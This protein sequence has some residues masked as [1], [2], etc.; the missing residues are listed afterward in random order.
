MNNSMEF[1]I[2]SS[3][4]SSLAD[5]PQPLAKVSVRLA[6]ENDITAITRIQ[7]Q[8]I[9]DRVATLDSQAHSVQE[10]LDWFNGH[11]SQEPIV[12][13]EYGGEVI[14]W[15]SLSQF[16]H[17]K[18]YA[19]VKELS[20]YVERGW[21]GRGVGTQLLARLLQMA[22]Q[23]DIYKIVLNTLPFNRR[24]IALYRK[25][26]FRTVGI[27]RN[28]GKLDNRWIDVLLMEK[29][30]SFPSG[31][32]SQQ[33]TVTKFASEREAGLSS[34]VVVIKIGG[35]TFGSHDTTLD[36]IVVLQ[37]RGIVPVVVH[38]GG[39]VITE[40]MGKQ[41]VMPRFVRGL[42]VTDAPSL[43]IA[44]AVLTGL[45]N[46][47]IVASL[48]VRGGKVIGV[49]GVD[50]GL[51]QAF[52]ADPTLG[53]VGQIK[54][55]N[56]QPIRSIIDSGA[57]PVIAP[58]A[59]HVPEDGDLERDPSMLNV[60]ADTVA[61]EIAAA[62][63]ASRLIFLTDV[64]GVVDSSRRLIPRLTRQQARALLHSGIVSGGMTPKLEAC[65]KAL[66]R[67]QRAQIVDGRRAG[68]LLESLEGTEA[69]T[70]VG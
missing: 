67:V 21:R 48:Q 12:V 8:G 16:S 38:G 23:L 32:G 33:D 65:L 14:G 3:D 10:Q 49:S 40:W 17:R 25:L 36:N 59:L 50:G 24:A 58:I 64:P 68:V 28:Q 51:L 26:G 20:V 42:R 37:Q 22:P 5:D 52:I 15:A 53:M 27:W 62:L 55:V 57:I 41:G 9:E 54:K 18:A 19:G 30:L 29:H 35:S 4:Q 61:G 66:K 6:S 47:E 60:N 31:R 43:E 63:G 46:K 11:G 56:P 45:V 1:P 70:I 34:S 7:N 69:G 2:E 13:A 44:V 39:K